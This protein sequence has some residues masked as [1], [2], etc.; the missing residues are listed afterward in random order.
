MSNVVMGSIRERCP[1][2]HTPYAVDP[3]RDKIYEGIAMCSLV[4]KACLLETHDKCD[5]YEEFLRELEDE[6]V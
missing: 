5:E 1:H 3:E 6:Q 4:D 2:Q